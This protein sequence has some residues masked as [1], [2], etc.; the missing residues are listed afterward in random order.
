RGLDPATAGAAA[1]AALAGQVAQQAMVLSFE[2]MFLLAGICFM[3]IL[4]LL[5]F[6]KV[7]RS[8]EAGMEKAEVHLEM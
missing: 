2:K 8:A 5:L 4:P 3:A 7:D 6:L 1:P